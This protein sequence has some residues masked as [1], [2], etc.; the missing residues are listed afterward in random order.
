MYDLPLISCVSAFVISA[1]A[2]VFGAVRLLSRRTLAY[3][4]FLIWGVA[5]FVLLALSACVNILC[6]AVFTQYIP[7]GAFG[8][9][10]VYTALLCANFGV[11]DKIVDERSSETGKARHLAMIAPIISAITVI[12]LCIKY[13]SDGRYASAVLLILLSGPMIFGVYLNL[14]HLLLPVDDM[15]ILNATRGCN[16]TCL[17]F[18]F[19]ELFFMYS[20]AFRLTGLSG[21]LFVARSVALLGLMLFAVKGSEKWSLQI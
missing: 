20:D 9:I 17:V 19:I 21:G 15:G 3:F 2:F 13:F 8:I 14:K 12:L 1:A 16:F 7:I 10:G 5:C 11:L 4:H 18:S 6:D